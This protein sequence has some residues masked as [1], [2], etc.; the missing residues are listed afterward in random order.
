MAVLIAAALLIGLVVNAAVIHRAFG[1]Q[2][3]LCRDA[4]ARRQQAENN[5][6]RASGQGAAAL[7]AF[8]EAGRLLDAARA[9]VQRY[10]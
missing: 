2:A 6:S 5:A 3:Q 9:D 8:Q 10:C 4:L 7:L 1:P